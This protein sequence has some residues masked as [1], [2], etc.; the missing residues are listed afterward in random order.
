MTGPTLPW[1]KDPKTGQYIATD[2]AFNGKTWQCLLCILPFTSKKS[3]EKH[4]NSPK[5]VQFDYHCPNKSC[6]MEFESLSALFRHV[7]GGSCGYLGLGELQRRV[8]EVNERK[9]KGLF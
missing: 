5:H 1:S 8:G 9:I 3:L 2:E 7:E 6:L 4:L